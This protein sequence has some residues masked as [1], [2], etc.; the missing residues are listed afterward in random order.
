MQ[1]WKT[2]F[3][4][5]TTSTLCFA[6]PPD[7][8]EG[9]ID[10]SRMVTLPGHIHRDAKAQYDQGR[11]EGS[12]QLSAVTL[13]TL[14]TPSQ[15]KAVD[16]LLAE[17][18]DRN[19]PSFHKWLTPDQYA[20]RFGLSQNDVQKI[21]A[22]LKSQGLNVVSVARGRNWIVFSGTAAQI[23]GALRTEIHRYNVNGKMHFANAAMPSIPAA[24][25]GIAGGFRGLDDFHP[26]PTYVRKAVAQARKAGPDYYDNNFNPPDFVAPGDIETI[27]DLSPLYTAGFDGT[28]QNMV[29][30]GQ[31]DVYLADL[32]DFRTGFGLNTITGCTTNSSGVITDTAPGCNTSNFQYVLDP[33]AGDP[34]VSLGDLTESDLDLEWSAATARG[35]KI[36][37]VNSSD[38]FD[39]YY[40]AIDNNLAPV[41]SM[42][43][44]VCEFGEQS[45]F[46]SDE[47]EL[48]EANLFGITFMNSSGDSGAA[49]CDGPQNSA[50]D[51]LA[52]YGLAVN[53]PA[54]SP[55]VTGVGG[56][57]ISYP[58]GFGSTY[59]GTNIGTNG[60][61]AQN[62]PLPETSWNDDV[63]LSLAYPQ[64]FSTALLWQENYAIVASGGGGSNCYVQTA[65]NTSCVS[66][67]PQP[68]WQQGLSVPQ[69]PTGV[70]YVP[71]VSLLASPNFPG[72]IY[73]TPVEELSTISPYDTESSSSCA[74]GIAAAVNGIASSN[75]NDPDVGPSLVGGT[76]A[77]APIFAGIVTI[78][79]QY[80]NG[81]SAA[82]LGNINPTLYTLA[83]TTSN[84]AF[85]HATSS[86][87]IVYCE[88]DT[89]AAPWPTALQCPGASGTTGTI[90]FNASNADATTGY[91]LV[92]GLGS[93]DTNNLAIAWKATLTPDF[94]LSASTLTPTSV[95]AGQSA[96][97]TLTIAP[98]SGSTPMTVD[99]A[100]ASCTGLPSGAA[101]VFSPTSVYFDGT[102]APP[103]T[104][105]ISTA[106]NMAASG[107]TTITITPTNASN[108]TAAVSLTVAA[109]NESFTLTTTAA[110]FMVAVGGTA[111]VPI[112]VVSANGFITGSGTGATT[113]LP[114]TYT[115]SGSPTLSTAEI[116]CQFSPTN[117][118]SVSQT[119]VTLNLVTTAPTSQ[120]RPPLG[121]SSQIFYAM[122]L[123]GLFG[124]VFAAGGRKRGRRLLSLIV[125]IGLSTLWLGSC[126]GSGGGTTTLSNPGTPAQTYSITVSATT[127]GAN[128][129]TSTL[130]FT[131]NVTQ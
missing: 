80:L 27:Y 119:A 23:E 35:A 39:S 100:P 84:G 127:G 64:D 97:S 22:W 79:N 123:P 101:C 95:P 116:S 15:Q 98:V 33:D 76:S 36:I 130:P 55:E 11:V 25:S 104:V 24:L 74:S 3:L 51:N 17:Q 69:A 86:T 58:S 45:F 1:F 75:P 6:A 54:S 8:I 115:C 12:F 49:G 103:V 29:I 50:T 114:L 93:V 106:P 105:T 113:A 67:F 94:A 107:P 81:T 20:D 128:P 37:F 82:G 43:Y 38:V 68:S 21:S 57:A 48:K 83:K 108:V 47:A 77:S 88:G 125:V 60:G 59:W 78:I 91:N 102:S 73:C 120:L 121:R 28:G 9:P 71:D 122:L 2:L 13:L 65:G 42:S 5:V 109:T 111:P 92:T 61:T 56:T 70:R 19:S 72:Y 63:E 89:P 129:I 110:T 62:P 85:H 44:G 87:N 7:R 10:S 31:T 40:Y 32:N 96:S 26:R 118:Q 46:A 53:Y 14:P 117:G 16:I 4:A 126:G 112:T 99:F 124:I 66:G 34:G 41:I 52:Q 90:G 18:Q 30:V 131:L